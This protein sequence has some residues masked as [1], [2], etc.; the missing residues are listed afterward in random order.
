MQSYILSCMQLSQY[1]M[2]HVH[3]AII[4]VVTVCVMLHHTQN[5]WRLCSNLIKSKHLTPALHSPSLSRG[6]A[7]LLLQG[8]Y[9]PEYGTL[10]GHIQKAFCL[11]YVILNHTQSLLRPQPLEKQGANNNC[12]DNN[13]INNT[14]VY[15]RRFMYKA[16]GK[17]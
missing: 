7:E 4:Y 8:V 10:I 12:A 9:E 17:H 5:R 6:H 13:F 11:I 14:N 15:C 1:A 16:T 3:A 2:P